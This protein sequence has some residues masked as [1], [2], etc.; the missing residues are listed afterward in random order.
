[1]A[2]FG[3]AELLAV[4]VTVVFA[5]LRPLAPPR[6]A[7][8]LWPTV[9]IYAGSDTAGIDPLWLGATRS[10]P[11][12][13]LSR[14]PRQESN[15]VVR[16]RTVLF[17]TVIGATADVQSAFGAVARTYMAVTGKPGTVGGQ[18]RAHTV[19]PP[20]AAVRTSVAVW[21]AETTG[22]GTLLGLV[23]GVI[24]ALTLIRPRRRTRSMPY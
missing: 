4:L 9:C 14:L 1:L 18:L 15:V 23:L 16:G 13:V 21:M 3:I 24:A 2:V 20:A 7:V 11:M 17:I 19:G 10:Y 12:L 5:V 8:V 6:P 22:F